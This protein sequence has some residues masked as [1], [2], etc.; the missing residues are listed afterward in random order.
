MIKETFRADKN[1]ILAK[2]KTRS[3][4]SAKEPEN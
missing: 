1:F 2:V 4:I 3:I